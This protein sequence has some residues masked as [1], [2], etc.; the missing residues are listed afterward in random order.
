MF[1]QNFLCLPVDVVAKFYLFSMFSKYVVNFWKSQLWERRLRD[2]Y[3]LAQNFQ[4][5]LALFSNFLDA[6]SNH[7]F[8][9]PFH[10][11]L[12]LHESELW[13]DCPVLAEVKWR[14][15]K[16]RAPAWPQ[17]KYFFE[18]RCYEKL[19]VELRVL[20]QESFL[21]EIFCLENF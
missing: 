12:V 1:C 9:D 14:V 19:P 2:I 5:I 4:I 17:V 13:S 8:L 20:S 6:V 3:F 15:G 21:A 16:F 7:F 11:S 18:T 10:V